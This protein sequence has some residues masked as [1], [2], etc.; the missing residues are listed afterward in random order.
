ML[1][2]V[3]YL[4]S[5]G[6][7]VFQQGSD[8]VHTHCM[9]C[10]EDT[11]KAGRLYVNVNE[12]SE[13][14]GLSYCFLCNHSTNLNGLMRHFGD[15]PV[16]EDVPAVEFSPV[17]EEATKFYHECLLNNPEAFNWLVEERGFD[18]QTIISARL[19]WAPG[20]SKLHG[21]LIQ[22]FTP[23]EIQE[24]GLVL[25]RF[26]HDFFREE[27]IIPYL[28][29]GRT[30]NMRGKK[31]GGK[32]RGLPG[33]SVSLY[34][35]DAI[36]GEKKALITEG[37]FCALHLQQLGFSAVGVPGAQTWKD[38]WDDVIEEVMRAYVVFDSDKAGKAGAEKL[39][40]KLGPKS[41]VVDIPKKGYDVEDYIVKLGKNK[42]DIEYLLSKAKG[43]IVV[44]VDEAFSRWREVEGNPNVQGL[45]FNID[46]LDL[47]MNHGLLKGQ[48]ITL[49]SKTGTGKQNPHSTIIPTPIGDRRFGDLE[50]G[51]EV[52]GLNGKPTKVLAIHEQGVTDAYRITFSDGTS[53]LAGLEHLWEVVSRGGGERKWIAKEVLTTKQIMD[54][55]LRCG[56]RDKEYRYRIP[57]VSP[58][59]YEDA[60]LFIPPYTMGALIANGDTKS[61]SPIVRT[62]DEDVWRRIKDEGVDASPF[63]SYSGACPGT[64]IRGSAKHL[65]YYGLDVKSGDKFIP[66]DYLIGSVAQRVALLKGLMDGDGSNPS[67]YGDHHKRCLRYHTTSSRLAND[68][69]RLVNSLGGTATVAS[70]ERIGDSG[71]PYSDISLNIM[72]PKE[73]RDGLFTDR[74][75][76]EDSVR[77]VH[78]PHRAIVSIEKESKVNQ[79]CITVDSPDSLYAIT[80]NYIMTHNTAFMVNMLQR[81]KMVKPDLKVMFFS[82]EQMRNEIFDRMYKTHRFYEP[83]IQPVDTAEWWRDSLLMVDKNMIREEEVL[84]SIYQFTY[85]MGEPP[86]LFIMD[87]L[88]YF[89]RGC[90]GNSEYER[91]TNAVMDLKAICKDVQ[92]VGFAPHQANR[93]ARFGEELSADQAKSSGGVEETSD[94]V[95]TMWTPDAREGV[96]DEDKTGEVWQRIKKNRNGPA[97]MQARYQWAPLSMAMVPLNDIRYLERAKRERK[98][99]AAGD[100]FEEAMV[101]HADGGNV[102]LTLD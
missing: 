98:Y 67:T 91:V 27:V 49:I 48:L 95:M 66:Y 56:Y 75:E 13:K 35:T 100:T 39:S 46:A 25:N 68:F 36:I 47:N 8:N 97:N 4:E 79:R 57:M 17:L 101:R 83:T 21:H 41:R 26:S 19:G 80:E 65:R 50:V 61:H 93:T 14:F 45:K 18:E 58:V 6:S 43:G 82:L 73:I 92:S 32:Y 22:R 78:V 5:K 24:S 62:P 38:E 81:M 33:K 9:F 28:D 59:Q 34:G 70:Q 2:V 64:R 52:F 77:H 89:A 63:K 7:E 42:E 60:K 16:E 55:G 84:D 37:E 12:D 88:G 30:Y 20:G 76:G 90:K 102:S 31:I 72:L 3:E 96:S 86:D 29:Y 44:S 99:A 54:N 15:D 85:E 71:R 87:Y 11:E 53:V 40:T 1:D 94:V 69:I 23:E 74:K 51:D 10:D